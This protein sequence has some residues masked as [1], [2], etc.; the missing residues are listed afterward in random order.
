MVF[1]ASPTAKSIALIAYC[2]IPFSS[3]HTSCPPFLLRE[4]C[5]ISYNMQVSV[6]ASFAAP[7][8]QPKDIT[9][10]ILTALSLSSIAEVTDSY[11]RPMTKTS[12]RAIR[13]DVNNPMCKTTP[14]HHEPKKELT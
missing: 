14:R 7:L 11:I 13:V 6:G 9:S 12:P 3:S 8:L 10:V 4:G 5:A 1:K 2:E